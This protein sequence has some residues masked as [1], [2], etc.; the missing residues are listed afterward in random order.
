[1]RAR[2]ARLHLGQLLILMAVLTWLGYGLTSGGATMLFDVGSILLKI[3]AQQAAWWI[4]GFG[5]ALIACAHWLGR[6]WLK[7]KA[8]PWAASL[9]LSL[10]FPLVLGLW[11][12]RAYASASAAKEA[13]RRL[14]FVIDTLPPTRIDYLMAHGDVVGAYG[15][16][17]MASIL[18]GV[19]LLYRWF[20]ARARKQETGE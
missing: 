9:L 3:P 18:L 6:A 17:L 16:F 11:S 2:I 20:G 7:G 12:W 14:D 19:F 8:V 4:F 15:L 1:M 13:Y 5:I 10:F